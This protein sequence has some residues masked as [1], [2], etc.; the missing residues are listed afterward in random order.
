MLLLAGANEFNRGKAPEPKPIAL[1]AMSESYDFFKYDLGLITTEEAQYFKK[2]NLPWPKNFIVPNSLQYREFK[3]PKGIVGVVIFPELN[4]AKEPG[5]KLTGAIEKMCREKREET[6][7]LIGLSPWGY[8]GE[9]AYLKSMPKHSVDILLGSGPGVE[10]T[11]ALMADGN[12]LW[13]R[14][15]SKGKHVLRLDIE[16]WPT[17][18]APKWKEKS[19]IRIESVVLTDGYVEDTHIFSIIGKALH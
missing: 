8:W 3:T 14:S 5:W 6:D 10:V 2:D 1:Q 12:I 17:D 4:G 7:L 18:D 19:N 11:G 13:N 16:R 15:Y 9:Q